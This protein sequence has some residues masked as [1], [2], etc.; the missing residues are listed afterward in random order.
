M[1]APPRIRR[2]GDIVAWPAD[3]PVS[4]VLRRIYAARGVSPADT[5]LG[6]ADLLVPDGLLGLEK[7]CEVLGTA[8]A[9]DRKIVIAGDYDADGATAIAVAVLG[10]RSLGASQVDYLVP[11]RF[12][13]GYGLSPALVELAIGIGA[14]VLMTVDNGIASHEGVEAAR[15]AGL[16]VVITDHHLPGPQLPDADAIV[17]PNQPGCHFASRNLAGVGTIFYVLLGLRARMRATGVVAAAE[18]N[19]AALLDLVALGTVADLVKLD[20][21][22]RILVAHGIARIR[23]G[24]TRPGILALLQLA[25]RD[26][27]QVRAGDLGFALAP[28]LNAAG[29]L[30]DM[31][32]GIEC[33]LAVDLQHAVP[34][35]Q[36]LDGLNRERRDIQARMGGEA[37]ESVCDSKAV[38]V[39]LFDPGW[40]E[41]VVGLVASRLKDRLHRPVIAFAP[42]LEPGM[43][44]GSGRSIQ[45]FHLR[46]ALACIAA[47]AP[48]MIERFGGHAM[49]AGLSLHQ[50][51][52][53][54]FAERFD[55]I[56]RL[57]LDEGALEHAI[58]SDGELRPDEM[59]LAAARDLEDAGPWGQGCPEPVFDGEFEIIER[60][61]MGADAQHQRYRLRS[62][63]GLRLEAVHFDGAELDFA[64][65][66]RA[67]IAYQLVINRFRGAETVQMRVLSMESINSESSPI[68]AP[69]S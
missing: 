36:A 52:R 28:R 46:D 19:L 45:G 39:C 69:L 3:S 23:A 22:N 1:S 63:E 60:R 4:P 42:A 48:G 31:R 12:T 29:R 27:A 41:G 59:N 8:I 13:M 53:A 5:G 16:Q 47:Q 43:L 14:Q 62:R 17:N 38:G 64:P 65:G 33:L 55:A 49:A 6:L 30:K 35:A 68:G 50:S 24:R 66:N 58:D 9:Q 34:L 20:R 10:L 61:A 37:I 2:R 40:H 32:A 18:P 54:E 67:R 26:P 25:G 57:S 21:N 56:C 51:R 44:K 15:S 11:N 7:A